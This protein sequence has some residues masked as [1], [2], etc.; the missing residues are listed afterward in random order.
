[1]EVKESNDASAICAPLF[2]IVVGS[3]TNKLFFARVRTL[4]TI[5]SLYQVNTGRYQHKSQ[6]TH[7]LVEDHHLEPLQLVSQSTISFNSATS[8]DHFGKF[9]G[10]IFIAEQVV[11]A[12]RFATTA[13]MHTMLCLAK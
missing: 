12:K 1:M 2:V 3:P 13:T 9:P 11:G 7:L 10:Q 6:S 5:V 8:E 4:S